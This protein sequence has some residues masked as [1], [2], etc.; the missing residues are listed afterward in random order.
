[1]RFFECPFSF[2]RQGRDVR[3]EDWS[4]QRVFDSLCLRDVASDR[5][6]SAAEPQQISLEGM[7]DRS[8][9]TPPLPLQS[10]IA[11]G[12]C[13]PSWVTHRQ[14]NMQT[15][16]QTDRWIYRQTDRTDRQRNVKTK[17]HA[18]RRIYRKG[19][20]AALIQFCS[21]ICK[22]INVVRQLIFVT[23]LDPLDILGNMDHWTFAVDCSW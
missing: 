23:K 17:G 7:I 11:I 19:T 16:R 8:W 21:L 3:N 20:L 10:P 9:E 13:Y 12:F 14:T 4:N 22:R 5:E 2:S 18:D 1:M 6:A 15:D